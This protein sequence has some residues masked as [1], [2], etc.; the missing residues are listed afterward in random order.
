[1]APLAPTSTASEASAQRQAEHQRRPGRHRHHL[2]HGHAHVALDRAQRVAPDRG[3]PA[4]RRHRSQQ[5]RPVAGLSGPERRRQVDQRPWPRFPS[6]DQRAGPP[7]GDRVE[8]HRG[9]ED[10]VAALGRVGG[11]GMARTAAPAPAFCTI[12]R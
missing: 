7:A 5:Q 8:G 11:R 9:G 4:H 3:G 10:L 6:G 12:S 2:R 1:M